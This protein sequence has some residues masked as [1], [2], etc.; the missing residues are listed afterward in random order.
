MA[1]AVCLWERKVSLVKYDPVSSKQKD[2]A[3]G[4]VFLY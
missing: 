1:R 4:I 2:N 3:V